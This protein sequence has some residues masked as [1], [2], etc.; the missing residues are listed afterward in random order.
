MNPG[1]RD[2]S[3]AKDSAF[4]CSYR[5]CTKG[6]SRA[7]DLKRHKVAEHDWC[8]VCDV[9]CEDDVALIEHRIAST[10]A[11]EGK[12]IA[13]LKCGDDFRCEAGRDR[14]TQLVNFSY[15]HSTNF[16]SCLLNILTMFISRLTVKC[17]TSNARAVAK[18]LSEQQAYWLTSPATNAKI[19][20]A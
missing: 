3:A 10:L 13:C 8:S 1:L 5:N 9:D 17:K 20:L 6:F 14:H 16:L 11:E 18:S 4:P 12:H 19:G 2:K 15:L 7:K